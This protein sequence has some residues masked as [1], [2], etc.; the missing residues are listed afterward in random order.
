MLL[1]SLLVLTAPAPL[2]AQ[3]SRPAALEADAP[4]AAA[5]FAAPVRLAAAGE[6]IAVEA[7]GYAAPTTF[8][9]DGDGDEDLVVGQ[10]AGGKMRVYPRTG[11]GEDGLPV[12]G[13][14]EWLRA[15]EDV[16]E[17]PGVW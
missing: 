1:E 12:F 16:A 13:A 15:G 5:R 6:P 7:P 2:V 4:R 3:D 11:T 10:F 9:V 14:G 17:V 8:D